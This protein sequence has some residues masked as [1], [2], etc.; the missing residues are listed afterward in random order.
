S[1]D[2]M[3]KHLK[4]KG[5]WSKSLITQDILVLAGVFIGGMWMILQ[6][7]KDSFDEIVQ[8]Q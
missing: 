4:L 1:E 5:I 8:H 2:A 6:N 7:T 3:K